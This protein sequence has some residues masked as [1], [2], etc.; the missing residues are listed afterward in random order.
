M[1]IQYVRGDVT[2]PTGGG[3]ILIVHVCNNIGRFN[4]GVAAAIARRFPEAKTAYEAWFAGSRAEYPPFRLGEVCFVAA[5][6]F[7]IEGEKIFI[8]NMLAQEGLRTQR[9]LVPLR[10]DALN[11]CLWKVCLEAKRLN[12]SVHMPRIGA[13]RAGGCWPIIESKIKNNLCLFEIP[14]FVYDLED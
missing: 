8:A 5:S 14:V 9:N 2:L 10:Y 13:G 11:T 7:A 1:D 6:G 12:A 4:A 3:N